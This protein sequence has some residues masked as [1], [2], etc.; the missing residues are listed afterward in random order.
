MPT[1]EYKCEACEHLWEEDK[2]ITDPV[3]TICP[4]CGEEKAKRLISGGSGFQLLGSGWFRD[5][6]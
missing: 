4:E 2:K 5:G 1:Y 3:T 6:Y